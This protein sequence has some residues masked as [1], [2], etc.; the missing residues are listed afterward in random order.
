M[1]FTD[2]FSQ[3]SPLPYRIHWRHLSGRSNDHYAGRYELGE[4][5]YRK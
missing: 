4:E 3:A 2:V 5:L 1:Q